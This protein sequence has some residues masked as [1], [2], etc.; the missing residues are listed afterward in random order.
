MSGATE[1]KEG[2]CALEVA[3]YPKFGS[4]QFRVLIVSFLLTLG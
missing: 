3:L 4:W 1:M 2:R